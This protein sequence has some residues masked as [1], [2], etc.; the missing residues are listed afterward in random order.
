LREGNRRDARLCFGRAVSLYPLSGRS[1]G[2]LIT[3]TLPPWAERMARKLQLVLNA[4]P[5]SAGG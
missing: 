4:A 1:W 3:A 2:W 5:P